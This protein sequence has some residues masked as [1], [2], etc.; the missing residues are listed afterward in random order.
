M[1]AF[2]ED[3]LE[4]NS[5]QLSSL[6]SECLR[7]SEITRYMIKNFYSLV[8]CSQISTVFLA[9]IDKSVERQGCGM[10]ELRISGLIP[11]RAWKPLLQSLQTRWEAQPTSYS[12]GNNDSLP[13]VKPTTHFKLVVISKNFFPF[14]SKTAVNNLLIWSP[15]QKLILSINSNL[16]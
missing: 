14:L 1:T 13:S 9:R 8:F 12:M 2:Y 16:V 6:L 7:A 11:G 4:H 10:G 15:T 3:D 5:A